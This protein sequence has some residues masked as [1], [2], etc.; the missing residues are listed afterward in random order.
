MTAYSRAKD[1]QR[2]HRS[3][4]AVAAICTLALIVS[5]AEAQDFPKHQVKV[6]VPFPAG[7]T[8]DS[9]PRV[10]ADFLSRKWGQPIIIENRA[11]AGGNVGAEVV[12]KAEPDGYTLLAAPPPPLVINQNIYQSLG[13]KPSE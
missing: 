1:T 12:A 8:A 7:G 2:A 6:V 13:F 5:R 9:M 4:A 11:G 10:I 3:W